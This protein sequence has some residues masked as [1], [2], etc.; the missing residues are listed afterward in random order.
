[1]L[2]SYVEG[3]VCRWAEAHG[4]LVRKLAWLGRRGAPDRFFIKAGRIVLIEFKRPGNSPELH[5]E[6]EIAR[7]RAAGAE[8]YVIDTVQAGIDVLTRRPNFWPGADAII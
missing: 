2:E 1:M 7:L 6:R 5:Q 3:S 4:W 8:V